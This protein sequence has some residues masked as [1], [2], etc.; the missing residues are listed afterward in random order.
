M[1]VRDLYPDMT[2]AELKS[3]PSYE[4]LS[5]TVEVP[6]GMYDMIRQREAWQGFVAS[7]Q[8]QVDAWVRLVARF[9]VGV[10]DSAARLRRR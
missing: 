9:L 6:R 4:P 8:P 3:H 7:V 5:D 10:S 1:Q 2:V